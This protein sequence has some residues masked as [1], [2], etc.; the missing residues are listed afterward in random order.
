MVVGTARLV[1][2]FYNNEKAAVKNRKLEELCHDIRKKFNV[3]ALE[4]ADFED[5]ERCVIGIAA[6]MQ[7]NWKDQ[8][9]RDVMESILKY[10][11][12]ISFAR[13][14]VEDWDLLSLGVSRS[15]NLRRVCDNDLKRNYYS[16][17]HGADSIWRKF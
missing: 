2:D 12:Q 8:T 5:P 16:N 3:S 13:V 10:V 6:V 17:D 14:T 7:E 4:I 1:L 9:S 11:D 15:A